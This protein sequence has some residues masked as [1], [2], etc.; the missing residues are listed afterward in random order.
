M[1][2]RKHLITAAGAGAL[3]LGVAAPALANIKVNVHN[4]ADVDTTATAYSNTGYNSQDLYA[5]DSEVENDGNRLITT[6]TAD[7]W[8]EANS[9][10]NET[11]I[12]VNSDVNGG[13]DNHGNHDCDTDCDDH[14][15]GNYDDCNRECDKDH[16]NNY[17]WK[18][19]FKK[20]DCGCPIDVDVH[21]DADVDTTADAT[22]D[23]GN[24]S[25]DVE[26]Y[27]DS[28]IEDN[29]GDRTIRTGDAI[30]TAKANSWVNTTLIRVV[31]R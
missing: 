24:N 2:L 6:G 16:G 4:K 1:N 7:S 9:T 28:E 29:G 31:R 27:N 26:L 21:N 20:D 12:A 15:W 13:N 22:S 10:V 8:A 17:W 18:K 19:W 11:K 5:D 3:L 14:E 23:T 30:S 25:Q